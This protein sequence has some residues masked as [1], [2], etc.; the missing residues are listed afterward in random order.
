MRR[1]RHIERVDLAALIVAVAL[2]LG[3]TMGLLTIAKYVFGISG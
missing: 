3:I 2:S 1:E